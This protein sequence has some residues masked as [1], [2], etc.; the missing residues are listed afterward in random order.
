MNTNKNARLMDQRGNTHVYSA[1]ASG[2][3][4]NCKLWTF[5]V[6]LAFALSL[7]GATV[8]GAATTPNIAPAEPQSASENQ[9]SKTVYHRLVTNP[10][11]NIF[12]NLQYEVHGST[13]VLSGQVVF[14]LT[15]S[16]VEDSV[17]GIRGVERIVNHVQNLPDSPFDNQIR[18][19]EYRSLFFGGSPLYYYSLGV[20]PGIHIIVNNGR[21]TLEGVVN[22]DADRNLA[23]LRA[24]MVPNVFSVTDHLRV[25]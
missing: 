23:I 2:K 22:S 12:D 15:S 10:W 11:Y 3:P 19:A 8:A 16:S 4:G 24:R 20:N 13:V 17:R 7:S 18:F 1:Q 5:L 21:V 14:P 25:A 6:L 9:I